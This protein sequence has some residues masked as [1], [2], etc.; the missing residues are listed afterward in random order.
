MKITQSQLRQLIK[1]ELEGLLGEKWAGDPKIK[2]LDKYG[3]EEMTMDQLESQLATTHDRQ[4]SYKKKHYGKADPKLTKKLRQI[5][6]AIRARQK[7]R[8]GKVDD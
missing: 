5:N 2:Q 8:F 6:F 7:D 1:E 3:K 4:D